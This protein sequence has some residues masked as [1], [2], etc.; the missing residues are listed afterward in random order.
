MIDVVPVK[1]LMYQTIYRRRTGRTQ[2]HDWR[3]KWKLKKMIIASDKDRESQKRFH[4]DLENHISKNTKMI[5][6]Q[7]WSTKN[8][9]DLLQTSHVSKISRRDTTL[10]F[11][12]WIWFSDRYGRFSLHQVVKLDYDIGLLTK[13]RSYVIFDFK[14]VWHVM[15]HSCMSFSVSTWVSLSDANNLYE[16]VD[17]KLSS[18][19]CWRYVSH[20]YKYLLHA[21]LLTDF[22]SLACRVQHEISRLFP[23]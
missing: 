21:S 1:Y 12:S 7:F 14:K 9:F 18:Y 19:Q 5:Q 11:A 23:I 17:V 3:E 4:I 10:R 20:S 16:R 2:D 8:T 22:S 13:L 15:I 6:K